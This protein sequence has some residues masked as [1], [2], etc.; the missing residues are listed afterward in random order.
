MLTAV[1]QWANA[2]YLE[3]KPFLSGRGKQSRGEVMSRLFSILTQRD[4][5]KEW[6]GKLRE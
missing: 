5:L 6:G 3:N 1:L 2:C 4:E